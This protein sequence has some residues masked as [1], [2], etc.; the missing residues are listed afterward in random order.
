MPIEHFVAYS[1]S[2]STIV[3]I[4]P[5]IAEFVFLLQNKGT[6]RRIEAGSTRKRNFLAL[7]CRTILISGISADITVQYALQYHY[8]LQQLQLLQGL[9]QKYR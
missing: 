9:T 2:R 8:L 4:E 1:T 3:Q 6:V 5:K 7:T